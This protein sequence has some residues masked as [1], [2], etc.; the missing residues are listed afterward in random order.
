MYQPRDQFIP[1]SIHNLR[2]FKNLNQVKM[3]NIT[4]E[5]IFIFGAG[6]IVEYIYCD[7]DKA[8]FQIYYYL[9]PMIY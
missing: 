3:N 8:G 7:A 2:I 9:L 4:I 6:G 1:S 5:D